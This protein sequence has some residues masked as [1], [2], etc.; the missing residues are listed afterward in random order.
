MI[1][2]IWTRRFFILKGFQRTAYCQFVPS[3]DGPMDHRYRYLTP[4]FVDGFRESRTPS[5]PYSTRGIR[6]GHMAGL[7][8]RCFHD[9]RPGYGIAKYL[10]G[11]RKHADHQEYPCHMLLLNVHRRIDASFFVC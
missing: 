11:I 6:Y 10:V 7:G 8:T 2:V 9:D 3:D 5:L 4:K 1:T